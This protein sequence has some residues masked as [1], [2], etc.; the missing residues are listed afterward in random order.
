MLDMNQKRFVWAVVLVW[1]PW[2][3]TLIG[4]VNVF[5]GI[6]N[7]K[8]TG[9]AAI[10]GGIGE[11][12]AM[13]GL[14]TMIVAQAVAIVWLFRSFSRH[15]WGRNVVSVVSIGMSGLLLLI[16]AFFLWAVWFQARHR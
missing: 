12:L 10:A 8:A 6:N 14:I 5:V 3:P 16:V 13:W 9:L 2:I 4:L 1:A 11:L 7:S 15:H